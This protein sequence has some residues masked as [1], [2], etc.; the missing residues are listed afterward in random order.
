MD[1]QGNSINSK[2]TKHYHEK[3]DTAL[4]RW[5][6]EGEKRIIDLVDEHWEDI[7]SLSKLLF[8]KEIIYADELDAILIKK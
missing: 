8:E 3:I 6:I 2:D 1:A 7:Q 4:G 5:M